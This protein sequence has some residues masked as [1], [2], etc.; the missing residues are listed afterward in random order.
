MIDKLASL[1][2]AT[3]P[4]LF[5][6]E[7]FTNFDISQL[8][9][10]RGV[11]SVEPDGFNKA[12]ENLPRQF[13]Y[14]P[15]DLRFYLPAD[16]FPNYYSNSAQNANIKSNQ[17]ENLRQFGR[18]D[19]NGFSNDIM[20]NEVS[21]KTGEIYGIDH[22]PHMKKNEPQTESFEMDTGDFGT[23]PIPGHSNILASSS[24]ADH[25]GG[26]SV[27]HLASQSPFSFYYIGKTECCIPTPK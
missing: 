17:N 16:Q 13:G 5:N 12:S 22:A 14:T 15:D 26:P 4:D 21:V 24:S 9:Y 2:A 1:A 19:Q 27:T 25:P 18:E 11:Q 7:I 23:D 3:R 10:L 8:D 20:G 6:K